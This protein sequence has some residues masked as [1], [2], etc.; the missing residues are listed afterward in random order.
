MNKEQIEEF[1]KERFENINKYF[2]KTINNFEET[3]IREF[4]RE[5][6]KL[7]VFLH[8]LSMES[9]DGLSYQI[10]KNMRRIYGYL[11]VL[12][13]FLQQLKSTYEYIDKSS[14]TVPEFYI[15]MIK[16]ELIYWK[17]PGKEVI[18]P[19]YDFLEDEYDILAVL[20]D[21]LTERSMNNFI[22]YAL[23]ELQVLDNRRDDRTLD[24]IRKFLEDIYYNL[25]FLKPFLTSRQTGVFEEKEIA[26]SLR[27]LENFQDKSNTAQFLQSFSLA[28]LDKRENLLI[29]QM[30]TDWL[31]EK[32]EM[33]GQLQ[34][35]LDAMHL[36]ATNFN[37]LSLQA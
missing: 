21:E 7:K 19:D 1:I 9:E 4:R 10:T 31:S 30:K 13:N 22:Y 12:Q 24:N 36:K 32:K 2:H 6:R 5:I 28:P 26:E 34:T 14:N 15:N 35:Q 11:G 18:D 16:N 23:Y 3:N 25:P 27:L 33:Q 20:P 29:N 17:N 37:E 8:L